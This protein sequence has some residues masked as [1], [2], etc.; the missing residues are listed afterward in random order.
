MKEIETGFYRRRLGDERYLT[1]EVLAKEYTED[2]AEWT[3]NMA[4]TAVKKYERTAGIVTYRIGQN[5][6]FTAEL[7]QVKFDILPEEEWYEYFTAGMSDI[8]PNDRMKD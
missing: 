7:H 5:Q 6:P 2:E 3:Q 4:L 8:H 1:V